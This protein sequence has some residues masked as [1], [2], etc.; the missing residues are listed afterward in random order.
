MYLYRL[1]ERAQR[2]E[3]Q[4]SPTSDASTT[5]VISCSM[6]NYFQKIIP[7]PNIHYYILHVQNI[8]S[9]SCYINIS[10]H[11]F[12][13]KLNS[14]CVTDDSRSRHPNHVSFVFDCSHIFYLFSQYKWKII[15][16]W[17]IFFWAYQVF[18]SNV[19]IDNSGFFQLTQVG[20]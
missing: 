19:R 14:L 6:L 3:I 9:F 18:V 7:I 20:K 10:H 17:L 4:M 15:P 12:L 13:K 16:V 5:L 2:E 1:F 11:L 8:S